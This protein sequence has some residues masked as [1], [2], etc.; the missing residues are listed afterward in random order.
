MA[1]AFLSFLEAVRR[2]SGPVDAAY[3]G[4]LMPRDQRELTILDSSG[5]QRVR[6][7]GWVRD[8]IGDRIAEIISQ[9]TSTKGRD[10]LAELA[11]YYLRPIGSKDLA[12]S[13]ATL[14][15]WR[16]DAAELVADQLTA[17]HPS[18]LSFQ[19]TGLPRKGERLSLESLARDPAVRWILHLDPQERDI[20]MHRGL[21]DAASEA[22]DRADARTLIGIALIASRLAPETNPEPTHDFDGTPLRGLDGRKF[23]RSRLALPLVLM[24]FQRAALTARQPGQQPD[25]HAVLITGHRLVESACGLPAHSGPLSSLDA[26]NTFDPD[27]LAEGIT[28]AWQMISTG[29]AKAILAALT[30]YAALASGMVSER[31]HH[32]LALLS[33]AVARRHS[34]RRALD[35]DLHHPAFRSDSIDSILFQLRFRREMLL[36]A[37]HHDPGSDWR[38]ELRRMDDLLVVRRRLLPTTQA[39]RLEKVQL[40]LQQ[41]ILLRQARELTAAGQPM[42]TVPPA[43]TEDQIRGAIRAIDDMIAS[44]RES[45]RIADQ[46]AD[47]ITAVNA[48][49]RKT[50]ADGVVHLLSRVSHPDALAGARRLRRDLNRLD[51]VY[52]DQLADLRADV[53]VL[54]LLAMADQAIR[55]NETEQARHY[56]TAAVAEL[57]E[58]IPHLAIRSASLAASIGETELAKH[59]VN[60]IP[61]SR[62]WPSYLRHL[63]VR[64]RSIES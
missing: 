45:L 31:Q 43:L 21:T 49:R 37:S 7:P 48:H 60:K 15:N 57:P 58:G 42:D 52:S 9:T 27:L 24:C 18:S 64:L 47:Q 38:P 36:L 50:E 63:V 32:D 61:Q 35:I 8:E 23:T 19:L 17:P 22:R 20:A 11:R 12:A 3:A 54:W 1:T 6:L 10:R 34:D 14:S 30:R 4:W 62:T 39:R 28:Y 33:V 53:T 29:E 59:L 55:H 46:D 25:R 51:E 26:E 40:H 5:A 41:G 56:L 2:G 44:M 16:R 13:R